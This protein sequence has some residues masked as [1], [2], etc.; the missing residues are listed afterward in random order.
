M[1][2]KMRKILCTAVLLFSVAAVIPSFAQTD[3]TRTSEGS[4][5]AHASEAA[6]TFIS[7]NITKSLA[8]LNDSALTEQQRSRQFE[9]LLL[10]LTDMRRVGIF[11]LGQYAKAATA[12]DQD[13]FVTAFQSYSETVYRSYFNLFSGQKLVVVGSS[14]RAPDDFIVGTKLIDPNNQSGQTPLEVNFRVR[15]DNGKPVVTDLSV[16]GVWLAVSQRDAFESYLASHGGSVPTLTD[17]V[18]AVT[19][20]FH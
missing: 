7:E 10:N 1:E 16:M 11:T 4:T 2:D 8:I 19:A 6:E 13:A 20:R 9:A 18:R 17:N 15:T 3:G 5:S 12:V 14:Q